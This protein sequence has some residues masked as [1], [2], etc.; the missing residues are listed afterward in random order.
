VLSALKAAILA[1]WQ[2]YQQWHIARKASEAAAYIVVA[3]AA[4]KN[5]GGEIVAIHRHGVNIA[6]S[7]NQ[8]LWR[9]HRRR[10]NNGASIIS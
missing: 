10:R 5:I 3:S 4:M 8:A 2:P 6:V 7:K 1:A 9:K